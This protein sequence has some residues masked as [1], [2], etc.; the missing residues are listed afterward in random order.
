[1][2]WTGPPRRSPAARAIIIRSVSIPGSP[3]T[4][5]HFWLAAFAALALLPGPGAGQEPQRGDPLLRFLLASRHHLPI[6]AVDSP[7]TAPVLPHGTPAGVGGPGLLFGSID[8]GAPVPRARVLVRLGPGG[9]ATL[10]RHGATIG[11]RA[12]DIVTARVPLDALEAVL[13][14]RG[15]RAMQAAATL[16]ALGLAPPAPVLPSAP[17]ADARPAP[18]ADSAALD[19]GFDALRRLAGDR[20]E[21]LAGRGVIV[22][23]YDSGLDLTHPDF[24]DAGGGT[25]VLFAWDQTVTGAGPGGLGDHLFDYGVECDAGAINAGTCPMVDRVGHGTHV[26]GTAAGDGSATGRG[27]PA[28]RFAGGAPAADLIIVKGGDGEFTADRLVDGVAYIFERAAALGRPAVVNLSLSTQSGPH[29]GTTLAER[30]LDALSGPGRIIVAGSGNAGDHRNSL[31]QVVNGP[32]HAQGRAAG[33]AH[34]LRVPSYEPAPGALNDAALMELWYA[35]ADSLTITVRSPRGDAVSAA[36]GDTEFVETPGGAVIILNAVGGPSL[37]NGDNGALIAVLDADP[38]M[39]PDPG[40]WTI[41]VT[42]HTIPAGGDYHL[43]LVGSTFRGSPMAGLEGGTTNRYLVGIP[44]SADRVLAAGAHVTRHGW[45]GLEEEQLFTIREQRGDIAY[46]SSPGPRRDGVSKPDLTAPGKMVISSLGRDATLWD[47]L[48]WLIE[49]DSVHVAL[50]GT[51][52]SSPLVAAA[53]A[54]LL[55]IE[56]QLTP[57]EARTLLRS[58]A[59]TDRFVPGTLPHPVWGAGKLDAAAAV[60]ELRP[61]G[62]AGPERQVTLSANP[63]RTDALVIG[64]SQPPRSMAIYTLAAER[65]RSFTPGDMG[66]VTTVWALDTDRGGSVANGAYVLV[67]ELPDERVIRKLLVARP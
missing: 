45:M 13:S 44:A 23:V 20:W 26:T 21:G 25:R 61:H 12:G 11:T 57:E 36:T 32:F 56:P 28:H 38:A 3:E 50:L 5:K 18:P 43:W 40:L 59:A 10:R 64:Y 2:R 17:A 14:E 35:G 54:I 52:V 7:A 34:G 6:E 22:G 53:V 48:S 24:R 67:V 46:F 55:Q 66:P 30:A 15:I 60:R 58:S 51:S 33:P 62:L 8:R 27:M 19:A 9:E 4:L 29:D 37:L 42:P 39:P 65:V 47:G 63:I 16:H 31:P 41:Q 1:M 49:A